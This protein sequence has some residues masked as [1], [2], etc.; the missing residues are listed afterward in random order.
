MP[1]IETNGT[2]DCYN[3]EFSGFAFLAT[4]AI[5]RVTFI[6]DVTLAVTVTFLHK[7]LIFTRH[8]SN[9]VEKHHGIL[10]SI[11]IPSSVI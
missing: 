7:V 6:L 2:C 11:K 10:L 1:T 9:S 3:C 8:F 4:I 5:D